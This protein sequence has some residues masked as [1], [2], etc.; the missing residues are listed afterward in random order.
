MSKFNS[1]SEMK[2]L[3][4]IWSLYIKTQERKPNGLKISITAQLISKFNYTHETDIRLKKYDIF[5][6]NS[7]KEQERVC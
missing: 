4:Q 2:S 6:Q 7:L 3:V 1:A 5:K